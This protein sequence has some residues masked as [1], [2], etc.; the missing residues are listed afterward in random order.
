MN[1]PIRVLLVDDDPKIHLLMRTYFARIGRHYALDAESDFPAGL[2][3]LCSG[4]YDVC[5]LDYA[6]GQYSGLDLI[7]AARARRCRT[8]IVMLTGRSDLV[9]DR[10]AMTA[11]ADDY[12]VKG[13]FQAEGLDRTVRYTLERARVREALRRSEARFRQLFEE[14]PL[15]M[16]IVDAD[17][18]IED[19]NAALCTLLDEGPLD[20]RGRPMAELQAR[21]EA[22][23][24]AAPVSRAEYR[25]RVPGR[26]VWVR[27][28]AAAL[29]QTTR[30][31]VPRRL[32]MLEDITERR[33][34]E[35]RLEESMQRLA[36]SRG[37]LLALLDSL[38]MGAA[39]V[40]EEQR[41][42]FLSAPAAAIFGVDRDAAVG[43]RLDALV[44]FEGRGAAE[45]AAMAARPA[46][47]REKLSIDLARRR[48]GLAR[49][50]EVDV[51][52]DPRDPRRRMYFFYDLTEMHS[53]RQ[54]L[55]DKPQF[56]G[57]VG[58]A[59]VMRALFEQIREAADFDA[60]VLV[61]GETGSGKEL[62]GRALHACSKRAEGPYIPV[63][64]AGLTDSLLGSQLFGHRRGAFTG[65]TADQVGVFE[66]ADGGT[67]FLDEIGDIPM[68]V[69]TRLL[70]VLQE[71][72]ITRLGESTPRKVDVRVI[73]ATHRDLN[74]EVA[75]GRF[76]LDLLYRIRVARL[77][78]PPLRDRLDDLPLLV[79]TFIAELRQ[80][81][82]KQITHISQGAM[83]LLLDHDWP[84]NVRELRGVI[85]AGFIRCRGTA[86]DVDHLPIEVGRREMLTPRPAAP[87]GADEP[88][89]I[90]AALQATGGSRTEAARLL[91]I[92]RAT[93]YRRLVSFGIDPEDA[94]A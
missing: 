66:A 4:D 74:A 9:A 51:A 79:E 85:E 63:N 11:G 59:P 94:S 6:L 23:E 44:R 39:F 49:H 91:G 16:A 28:T 46:A 15:G 84:G 81:T 5:L 71:R 77:T 33:A 69:Q 45:L 34:A 8:P 21:D 17:G 64:C 2:A 35:A 65:A 19:C 41:V 43:Q 62:V 57:I 90:R 24:A 29:G 20:L 14:C 87:N 36:Q 93:F 32:L 73:A 61:E 22:G 89:R 78:I 10:E 26:T 53:L 60:T 27:E 30:D 54:R 55:D 70:R 48:G 3:A 25:L 37:D 42:A 40:D 56:H 72:E 76:R 38:R 86:L 52:D 47:E 7:H 12:L 75:A 18:R 58:R 68:S 82:G 88:A 92:S 67:L 13:T 80:K 1:R 31:E 50:L 83:A